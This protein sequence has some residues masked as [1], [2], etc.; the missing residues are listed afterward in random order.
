M[1]HARHSDG[2]RGRR[3]YSGTE[4]WLCW[5]PKDLNACSGAS[6]TL[7]G[8]SIS[9]AAGRSRRTGR[10]QRRR[11]DHHD[12]FGHGVDIENHGRRPSTGN[13]LASMPHDRFGPGL[14]YVPEERDGSFRA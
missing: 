2:P 10:P 1:A 12:P 3:V 14:A 4:R 8:V 13:D 11:Q 5:K 7:H 6:H 9:V